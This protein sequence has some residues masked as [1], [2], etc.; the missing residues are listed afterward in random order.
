[1]TGGLGLMCCCAAAQLSHG[2]AGYLGCP[3]LS[4][5]SALPLFS[6][7]QELGS[8]PHCCWVEDVTMYVC[9]TPFKGQGSPH[10]HG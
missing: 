10:R 4:L 8:S 1:M 6:V 7:E 9:T 5:L 2:E 3:W